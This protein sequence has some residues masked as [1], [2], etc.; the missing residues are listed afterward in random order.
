MYDIGDFFFCLQ[1]A[2]LTIIVY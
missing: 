2:T 1:Y